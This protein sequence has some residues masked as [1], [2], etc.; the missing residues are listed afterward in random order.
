MEQVCV[1]RLAQ[2]MAHKYSENIS[3]RFYYYCYCCYYYYPYEDNYSLLAMSLLSY[4]G[5]YS[6]N[7]LNAL[8]PLS[9]LFPLPGIDYLSFCPAN[10]HS[11]TAQIHGRSMDLKAFMGF[12]ELCQVSC[13]RSPSL[14]AQC[15]VCIYRLFYCALCQ[16]QQHLGHCYNPKAQHSACA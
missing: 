5:I 12:L 10:S 3:Y 9:L 2:C 8:G 16:G 11:S 7:L 13:P 14:S 4:Q 15:T 1:K 6:L